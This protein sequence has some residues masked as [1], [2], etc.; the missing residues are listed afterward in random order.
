MA[1]SDLHEEGTFKI[2]AVARLTGVSTHT[3]RKWES[4]YD[5]VVPIRT[6][7]GQRVYS[8]ADVERL[9]LIRRLVDA[10]VA[11]RDVAGLSVEE[12]TK[13]SAHLIAAENVTGTDQTRPLRTAVVGR[14][15]ERI[16]DEHADASE[17]FDIVARAAN[18]SGFDDLRS[19]RPIDLLVFECDSVDAD[20]RRALDALVQRIDVRAAVVVYRFGSR[21]DLLSLQSPRY[22]TLRAPTDFRTFGKVAMDLVH[23]HKNAPVIEGVAQRKVDKLADVPAPRLS[24][25]VISQIARSAPKMQCECPQHL[26]EILTG[27]LAFEQYSEVCESRNPQDAALHNYLWRSAAQARA[28]FE[29]AIEFVAEAEG[30]N[31]KG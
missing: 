27:L 21:G 15:I 10:G 16:L 17:S 9:R 8:G 28:L 26:A 30:I 5:A 22:T 11:P 13:K 14:S 31:I 18:A 1:E 24:R 25:E 4:R 3:L 2:G 19:D 7:R 6:E 23:P 20:T 12:L 29:D